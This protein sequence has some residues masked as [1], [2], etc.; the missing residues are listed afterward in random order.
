M[1][2]RIPGTSSLQRLETTT[3]SA[4]A[5]RVRS[6]SALS[7]ADI[8][9]DED[10]IE[11]PVEPRARTAMLPPVMVCRPLFPWSLDHMPL[12]DFKGISA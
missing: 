6:N 2:S 10:F 4:S 8:E 11:H 12:Y 3:T 9:E 7:T 5:G 1:S